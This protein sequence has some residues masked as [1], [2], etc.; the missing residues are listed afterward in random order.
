M[1]ALGGIIGAGIFVGSSAAINIA[2]PGVL[3]S[4]TLGGLLVFFIMRMLGE[5]AHARPGHGSFAEYAALGLGRWAAFMTGWLYWYFWVITVGV[6]TIAG[7]KL[8][9]PWLLHSGLDAPVW[10]IGL[11][12]VT[13]MT[14]TNLF[15][16]KTYG[17]LEF[18]FALLKVASITAFILLGI[19]FLAFFG[20]SLARTYQTLTDDGGIFPNGLQTVLTAIPIVIFSMM[21]SEVATIAAV[22]SSRPAENIAR[23]VRTVALRILIFYVLSV[24]VVVAIVPWRTLPVGF[25]PFI[26]A[27]NEMHIPGAAPAMAVIVLTAVLSCLNS[28]IYVTSRMLHELARTGDAPQLFAVTAGNRVP[29]LGILLGS[30]AGFLAA[31]ASIISP[32]GVF[33]FLIN[34]SGAIILII[35]MIIALGEI[36]FR[37]RLESEGVHLALKMWLFPWL[38][39]AVV[40][41]IGVVLLLMATTPDLRKQLLWSAVS[42]TVVA[43]AYCVR[44]QLAPLPAIRRPA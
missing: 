5:M 44:Q 22:E 17:E 24:A 35:Y 11:V 13:L 6:E 32:N 1:I 43:I 3:V 31:T 20:P 18:W 7:A 14:A 29:R 33:L 37:R 41:G 40:G 19:A 39:W 28:G 38:S 21:G 8:L 9:Q 30:V 25:S 26:V 42:V 15:S 16:V 10:A 27:L 34:T 23:A 36:R 12:L 4:Y 2:G